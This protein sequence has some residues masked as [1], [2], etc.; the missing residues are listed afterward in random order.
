VRGED[1]L[2]ELLL[3]LA[4]EPL[5]SR[6]G[7]SSPLAMVA[8]RLTWDASEGWGGDRWLLLGR[9]DADRV[10]ALAT[11]WDSEDDA[12][13]FSQAIEELRPHILAGTAQEL[14]VVLEGDRVLVAASRGAGGE[15]AEAALGWARFE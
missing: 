10:L 6:G 15:L 7:I 9:G 4:V 11:V 12:R 3:G 13:E 5:K 2:G 8:P 1:T 14:S